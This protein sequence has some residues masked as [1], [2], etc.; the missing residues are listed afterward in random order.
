MGE[1]SQDI[2]PAIYCGLILNEL[3]SN[4]LKYAFSE[5]RTGEVREEFRPERDKYLLSVGDD[6]VGFPEGLDWRN[7]GT[8]GMQLVITLTEQLEGEI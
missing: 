5:G 2:D 1:V 4:S 3:I 7:T 8:L 6:G